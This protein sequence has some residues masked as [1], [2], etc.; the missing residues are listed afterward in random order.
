MTVL[1][2]IHEYVPRFEKNYKSFINAGMKNET[3]N[4]KNN[5]QSIANMIEFL[6]RQKGSVN[7]RNDMTLYDVINQ[8]TVDN[9]ILAQKLH[10]FRVVRN[11]VIHDK[12]KKYHISPELMEFCAYIVDYFI[13]SHAKDCYNIKITMKDKY[14]SERED[15]KSTNQSENANYDNVL[16]ESIPEYAKDTFQPKVEKDE[17]N[18]DEILIV[19]DNMF[20]NISDCEFIKKCNIKRQ[21]DLNQL[22]DKYGITYDLKE[23]IKDKLKNI[24]LVERFVDDFF[25]SDP[26]KKLI[27]KEMIDIYKREKG[28]G[29]G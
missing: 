20:E 6:M 17:L 3:E 11:N 22:Y 21:S 2:F 4:F 23:I 8:Y 26:N 9:T 24:G 15:E 7:S 16:K 14:F 13:A 12:E 28:R 27:F 5:M 10:F 18:D 19:F 25:Q 29:T 1:E